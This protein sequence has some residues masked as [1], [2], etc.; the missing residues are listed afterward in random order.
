MFVVVVGVFEIVVVGVNCCV[1]DDVLLVIV[2]VVVYIGKLVI[3]YLNS[4]EGWDGWCCVWVGL[5]WFFGFF[6]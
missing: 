4:G 5:W 1:F 2:F 6:G 3:V